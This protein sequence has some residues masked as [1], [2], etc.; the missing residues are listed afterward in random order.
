[1]K[2]ILLYGLTA[3]GKSTFCNYVNVKYGIP[4]LQIRRLFESIV[5]KTNAPKIYHELLF[6]NKSRVAWLNYISDEIKNHI[7]IKD[8]V[9]IEGLFT[10][11]ESLWFKQFSTIIIIYIENRSLKNRITHFCS[12]ENLEQTIGEMTIRIS[13]QGRIKAGVLAVKEVADIILENDSSLYK[14]YSKIDIVIN[15]YRTNDQN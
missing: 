5:G 12:R 10:I 13:D 4:I 8:L 9:I 11:E 7:S 1:M 2:I 6:Q 3:S 15:Q 14:F